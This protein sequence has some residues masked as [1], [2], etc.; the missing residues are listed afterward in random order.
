MW[1]NWNFLELLVGVSNDTT[2][3]ENFL[4]IPYKVKNLSTQESHSN[5]FSQICTKMFTANLFIEPQI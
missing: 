4:S 3:L 2:T 1:S 5:V